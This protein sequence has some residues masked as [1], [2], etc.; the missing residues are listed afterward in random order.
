M[1]TVFIPSINIMKIV[2]N[3]IFEMHLE[4]VIISEI[5]VE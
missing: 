1:L 3:N 5:S 4:S 2:K